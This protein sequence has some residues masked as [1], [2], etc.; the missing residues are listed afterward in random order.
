MADI[1]VPVSIVLED[2]QLFPTEAIVRGAQFL[3][4]TRTHN[5]QYTIQQQHGIHNLE[6]RSHVGLIAN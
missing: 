3:V 5:T 2:D 4:L 1:V 6:S